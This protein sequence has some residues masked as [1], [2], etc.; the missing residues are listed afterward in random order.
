MHGGAEQ[1]I[2][3]W[4]SVLDPAWPEKRQCDMV[5]TLEAEPGGYGFPGALMAAVCINHVYIQIYKVTSCCSFGE[6][7]SCQG[8][9][10][11]VLSTKVNDTT[12]T[13]NAKNS[14][15][16]NVSG[17][18]QQNSDAGTFRTVL[19]AAGKNSE[20]KSSRIRKSE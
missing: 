5:P 12:I 2:K 1:M 7:S 4:A 19:K 20:N 14:E 9:Q 3:I 16:E 11:H 10:G 17:D 15:K 8:Y 13:R 6:C 18:P